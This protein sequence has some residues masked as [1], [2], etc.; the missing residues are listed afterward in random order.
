VVTRGE[1]QALS[2]TICGGITTRPYLTGE[3]ISS[4][5]QPQ[6]LLR[7]PEGAKTRMWYDGPA[8]IQCKF[9][10]DQ[11]YKDVW[12]VTYVRYPVPR[13]GHVLSSDRVT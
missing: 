4:S 12:W 11:G 5:R 2:P 7:K 1:D 9:L 10:G 6:T 8:T 13:C 3:E